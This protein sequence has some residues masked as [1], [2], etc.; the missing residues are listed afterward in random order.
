[1]NR[2]KR[3]LNFMLVFL[4]TTGA[5]AL[6]QP[7]GG[8]Y[9]LGSAEDL[10]AFATGVNNGTIANPAN[11]RLTADIN[12]NGDNANQWTPIGT[13]THMYS[14]TFDGQGFTIKNLYYKQQVEGV[15]LFGHV[16]HATAP[17]TIMNVRV[18]GTI[19]NSSD[20][21]G[22]GSDRSQTCAGGIL[23]KGY[24]SNIK[25][26]NCSFSGSVISFSNV[27]GIVGWGSVLI[28]NCYNEGNVI[29]HSTQGQTGSGVHGYDGSPTLINCYNV[30][31]ITNNGNS[32]SF[33]G[34]V[35]I[36]GT[37]TNCYYRS[38]CVYNGNGATGSNPD[39]S[40]TAMTAS[41]MKAASFV[42]T[43]N[44]NVENLKTT[45]PEICNWI[46]S[47]GYPVHANRKM[48]Y[49]IP[50][51]GLGTYSSA[52]NVSLPEGLKAYYCQNYDAQNGTIG[53]TAIEGTVPA[54]T[55][56]LLRGTAGATY[57]LT[58]TNATAGADA[59]NALVAVTTQ[60]SIPQT[61]DGYT[62][63]GLNGGEFK[64]V[65]E[66]GGTVKANRAY[67]QILTTALQSSQSSTRGIALDWDNETTAIGKEIIVK[68]VESTS[69]Q[70][71]T[72]GGRK[73]AGQPSQKGI[74]IVNG[75]KVVI[76]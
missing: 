16:G 59:D 9:L 5:W 26:I 60:T 17:T 21:A 62:N 52:F 7:V 46:V 31:N 10:K 24:N 38:G 58:G 11:A 53:V 73:L 70:W 23:G 13:S 68:D 44:A 35:N 28:V 55:G 57:T 25:I 69:G 76:K 12:L 19:D 20:G 33:I 40:G 66:N 71:Y 61:N 56:V 27:G 72:I 22:A 18:E 34:A 2:M 41:D 32:T 3:L 15:G 36:S 8:Y 47:E 48:T 54:S 14:G 67:L 43:L 74:Y 75:K 42:T 45:Y 37:A 4:T 6:G 29:F 49:T 50:S 30:G 1:M 39:H 65:N 51:S 64:M 63:F